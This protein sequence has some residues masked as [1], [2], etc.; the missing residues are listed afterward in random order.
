MMADE[1]LARYID[2]RGEK[3]IAEARRGGVT[4]TD[5]IVRYMRDH[6]DIYETAEE[7]GDH[8]NGQEVTERLRAQYR[9]QLAKLNAN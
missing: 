5:E 9:Q 1:E 3:L 6:L 4:D 7:I 8:P 2:Q